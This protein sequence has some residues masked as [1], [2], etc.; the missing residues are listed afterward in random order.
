MEK[1]LPQ[2]MLE[3]SDTFMFHDYGGYYLMTSIFDQGMD[4]AENKNFDDFGDGFGGGGG[5]AF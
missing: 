4:I 5:D 3:N 2:D 1:F